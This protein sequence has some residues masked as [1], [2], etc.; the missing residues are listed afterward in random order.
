MN[1]RRCIS[2]YIIQVL[3][4]VAAIVVVIVV[5]VLYMLF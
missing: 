5:P 3:T 1:S 2:P 4:L